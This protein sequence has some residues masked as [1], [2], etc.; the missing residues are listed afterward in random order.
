M[1]EAQEAKKDLD[2]LSRKHNEAQNQMSD[3]SKSIEAKTK[4]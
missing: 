3:W 2:D 1:Q 4:L